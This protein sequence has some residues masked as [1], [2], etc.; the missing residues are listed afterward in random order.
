MFK[1]IYLFIRSIFAGHD[2]RVIELWSF[3]R[4][5]KNSF[6]LN[7][8]I[9]SQNYLSSLIVSMI[10]Q[11]G[12]IKKPSNQNDD[13]DLESILH[14][15]GDWF[16]S[17]L[18]IGVGDH[19]FQSDHS[20]LITIFNIRAFFELNLHESS[21]FSNYSEVRKPPMQ[22]KHFFQIALNLNHLLL[23]KT[24]K[25]CLFKV[26]QILFNNF[27]VDCYWI[28]PDLTL[29][30]VMLLFEHHSN[31]EFPNRVIGRSTNELKS[32]HLKELSKMIHSWMGWLL[33]M[34]RFEVVCSFIL[35]RLN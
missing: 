27:D 4:Q 13:D 35:I 30:L 17:M 23:M 16:V 24:R 34:N 14:S 12:L 22:L 25:I 18:M 2:P 31:Q 21:Y 26:K 9:Y 1:C 7:R 5:Q 20:K 15:T 10:I 33:K 6:K 32:G 28:P 3:I 29:L 8:L 11:Y 19:F